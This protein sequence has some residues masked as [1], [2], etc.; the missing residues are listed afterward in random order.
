MKLDKAQASITGTGPDVVWLS[1]QACSGCVTSLLNTTFFAGAGA[2]LLDVIDLLSCD[3]VN[4]APGVTID[5]AEPTWSAAY[6]TKN[7]TPGS[8]V[9][10]VEGSTPF[11]EPPGGGIA[12]VG[13]YCHVGNLAG[14]GEKMTQNLQALATDAALVLAIGTCSAFGGIPAARGSITGATKTSDALLNLGVGTPCVNIPGCPPHPDW[15]V[16]TILTYMADTDI[17]DAVVNLKL[18]SDGCPGDYYGE[19]QCNAGPC[20]WRFNNDGY[21]ADGVTRDDNGVPDDNIVSL[22]T[23]VVHYGVIGNSKALGANK[24]AKNDVGCLGIL[25]CKGRKT[26]ADCSARKWNTDAATT[27][28]VNWCVESRGG[29]QGC[30]N[31]K[32]PDG[33][34]KFWTIP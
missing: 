32:F 10:C 27:Y 15:I 16:G 17:A 23:G 34:G 25:G 29:C 13:D 7:L 20:V 12:D 28:G 5:N 2:L 30:A 19:Y 26:K 8:Y 6:G 22:R 14:A 33:V 21:A 24:W 11:A 9:L 3:T 4:A 1:G 18:N 31:P